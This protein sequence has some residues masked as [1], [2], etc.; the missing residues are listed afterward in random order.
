MSE[1][2][3]LLPVN[4]NRLD[5]L[6]FSIWSLSHIKDIKIC[7]ICHKLDLSHVKK[8]LTEDQL[9]KIDLISD[10]SSTNLSEL[11]NKSQKKYS[12]STVFYRLD[13]GDI[14]HVKKF[15]Y[16]PSSKKS[17]LVH[18]SL[19]LEE[20]CFKIK[21]YKGRYMQLFRNGL[22]HSSFSFFKVNY[23][24]SYKLAQDYELSLKKIYSENLEYISKVLVCKRL[25]KNGNTLKKRGYSISGSINSKK[26][27]LKKKF[28]L[29]LFIAILFEK[30]KLAL[31]NLKK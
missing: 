10:F 26:Q 2:V 23:N 5:D 9:T 17:L 8:T 30:I 18:T 3:V 24:E 19:L 14:V 7:L 1:K 22:V 31:W 27:Q 29:I 16:A 11:L 25:S 28:S 6:K 21:T 4:N 15:E 20:K 13:S 12:E